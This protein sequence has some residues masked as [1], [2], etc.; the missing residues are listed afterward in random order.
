MTQSTYPVAIITG[1]GSGIGRAIAI[2]LAKENYR[3]ALVGRREDPLEETGQ[4]IQ[5]KLHNGIEALVIASDVGEPDQAAVIVDRT[6][7]AFGRVDLLVNNAASG[8]CAPVERID[9][10]ELRQTF[11]IDLF[12]PMRLT[13]RLWDVYRDQGGGCVINISS[14]ATIDPFP[15]LSIYAAAKSGLESLTRS[16]HNEGAALGINAYAIAPGAVETAMLRSL[17]SEDELPRERTLDP[18]EIA[19]IVVQCAT[20]RRESDRGQHDRGAEPLT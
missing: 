13:A 8:P 16:T 19:G 11:E 15:G 17:L 1:A 6:L 18:D 12:G 10:D 9:D 4:L 7:R 3:I 14:M 2:A 20:R 5:A